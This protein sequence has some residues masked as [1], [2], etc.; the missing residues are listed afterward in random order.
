MEAGRARQV[1]RLKKAGRA[2]NQ[3][4]R[5]ADLGR[6]GNALQPVTAG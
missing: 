1:G 5:Q 6:H 2:N 3:A 4:G